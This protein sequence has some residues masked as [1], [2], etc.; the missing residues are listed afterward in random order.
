MKKITA[1]F[2]SKCS[3][4]GKAI[5]KGESMIYDYSTRLCYS[6]TSDKAKQFESDNN[7]SDMVTAQ[8]SAYF[9]NFCY[10]NNI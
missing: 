2:N 9:D 3:E 4:T 1:K 6:L 5:K 7:T 8:E 10:S